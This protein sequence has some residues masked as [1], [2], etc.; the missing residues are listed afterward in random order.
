MFSATAFAKLNLCLH[1]SPRDASGYHPLESIVTFTTFGDILAVERDSQISLKVQGE[2][3]DLIEDGQNNIVLKAA[4]ML[5]QEAGIKAGARI[6]LTKNI[7]VGAGLGGGSAD[8]ATT[9]QLLRKMWQLPICDSK[10]HKLA[11]ELGSD[12]P[13][14]LQSTACI[15]RGRGEVLQ[16]IHI[17]VTRYFVVLVYPYRP[18]STADVFAAYKAERAHKT[19]TNSFSS[20]GFLKT[21]RN[22]ANDLQRAAISICPEIAEILLVLSTAVQEP[23]LVRMSGSGSCCFALFADKIRAESLAAELKKSH[24]H[25]WVA[26]SVIQ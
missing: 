26:F 8:A 14:C 6:L 15:A 20:A 4:K 5:Q 11:L 25:W 13:M 22:T 2:F 18:V 23:E 3:A 16:P 1:V 17:D 12:V 19:V 21:L 9:L 10:L 7:P 24:P